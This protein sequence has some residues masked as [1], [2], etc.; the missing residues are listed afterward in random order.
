[1]FED[2]SDII[3]TDD[4]VVSSVVNNISS[5]N[6][7]ATTI[8]DHTSPIKHLSKGFILKV[9]SNFTINFK[10]VWEMVKGEGNI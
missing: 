7:N 10:Q 8:H 6:K 9:K 4:I 3:V 5:A 2:Y 1:M